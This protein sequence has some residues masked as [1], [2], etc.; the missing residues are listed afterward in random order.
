[1]YQIIITHLQERTAQVI[2][3]PKL[4]KALHSFKE[5]C[6][7]KGYQWEWTGDLP[8]AGGIGHDYRI[9]IELSF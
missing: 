2:H 5:I 3:Y 7:D 1:M 4:D 8:T 9:E 6:D